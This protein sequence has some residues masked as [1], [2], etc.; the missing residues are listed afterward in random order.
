MHY[1]FYWKYLNI[2]VPINL[3]IYRTKIVDE[4][5]VRI[6]SC[7]RVFTLDVVF[8]VRKSISRYNV[9]A[10]VIHIKRFKSDRYIHYLF[11]EMIDRCEWT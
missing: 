5:R 9:M 11:D 7:I 8:R 3:L 2:F 4:V 6:K 1:K 10:F